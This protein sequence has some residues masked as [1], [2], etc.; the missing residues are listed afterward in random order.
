MSGMANQVWLP[1]FTLFYV[2][3]MLYWARVSV[4][5]ASGDD[6]FFSASHS[7]APWIAAVTIAGA[8]MTGWFV[9]GGSQLI[10]RSGFVLPA[11]LT[12]G[13]TVALPGVVFF[14]RSWFVAKRL[15]VSSQAEI[16]RVYYQSPFLVIV[17]TLTA[18]LF[19]VGLAGLQV[20]M[21]AQLAGPL[22]GGTVSTLGASVI[23]GFVVFAGA[24]IG[25][26]RSIGYFGVV[27][28]VLAFA[29]IVTLAGFAV[30]G[31]GSFQGLNAALLTLSGEDGGKGVLNVGKVILF[32]PGLGRGGDPA[33]AQTAVA[34]LSLAIALMGFQAGPLAL[35]L[36]LSMRSPHGI[37]A[38][39]TWVTT[40]AL[41]ALIVAG[42]ALIGASGLIG[43]GGLTAI[44]TRIQATSPWFAAWVFIGLAAAVQLLAGLAT[45]ASAEGLVRHVY[46]PYFRSTL[47]KAQSIS[48]TR[49]AIAVIAAFAMVMQNISP[50][51]LSALAALALPISLQLWTPMLGIT[52]LGWITKPAAATGV[53]FGIAGVMLTE[54]A[55]YQVLSF[56]GLELPWGRWPWTIHSAVWGMAANL[57]AVLIISAITDRN[58]LNREAQ[59]IRKLFSGL[60]AGGPRVQALQST[61][62]CLVLVW[63]FLAVGPGLIWGNSAFVGEVEGATTWLFGMPS[64]WA[65][66]IGGWI[67]GLGLI[68]FLSYKMEMAIPIH[69]EIPAY[70]PPLRLK[71][72]Q[73]VIEAERLRALIIIGAGGFALTVLIAFSFG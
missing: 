58:A 64:L 2:M 69:V 6:G 22:T 30:L 24:G 72:D 68:W 46:R 20:R 52:W 49:I 12:A 25:G 14:K 32:T 62:W 65:W 70:H 39:Q 73:S 66:S 41:G 60:L 47:T 1:L 26:M 63:F 13:V 45:F 59:E 40:G 5:A 27:Q 19:A 36:V 44:L 51:T 57:A 10:A 54:P 67:T 16:F 53:G 8:S 43:D 48:L 21:L 42:V 34:N 23:F 56:F 71:T 61:A 55:G 18:L 33:A 11:L 3:V 7:L 4:R 35:K 15:R 28:T 29:A 50:M 38:G 9:L 31:A 37:A 17:S